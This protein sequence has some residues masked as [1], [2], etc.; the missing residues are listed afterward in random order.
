MDDT[1]ISYD[2]IQEVLDGI[3]Q[4]A[5][6]SFADL[7]QGMFHGD[8]EMNLPQLLWNAVIDAAGAVTG[9]NH[10]IFYLLALA[11]VGAVFTNFAQMLQKKQVAQTAFY[12]TYMLFFSALAA[13]Y[14]V[15]IR[16]TADGMEQVVSFMK[17]LVP[18]YFMSL[19]FAADAASSA[20][21]YQLTLI[22]IG[23]VEI[24]LQK[25][26]LPAINIY[27]IIQLVNQIG[28]EPHMTKMAELIE[29]GIH[30]G[31][32]SIFVFIIGLQ[33]IQGLVMPE[34]SAAKKNLLI[35]MGGA[36]PGVGNTFTAAAETIISSASLLK[37]A[38][39]AAGLLGL[40]LVCI[41]PV[42]RLA[43]DALLYH[44]V[45]AL[46]QP[47]ADKRILQSVDGMT[48]AIRLLLHM[49]TISGILFF[50]SIAVVCILSR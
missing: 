7:V 42:A 1:D 12:A 29:K 45:A 22:A 40:T 26:A 19:A 24:F 47:V 9:Q 44:V 5:S 50:I 25:V 33:V 36:V 28:T 27:F 23:L 35:R 3:F 16:E 4:N 21:F 34:I 18:A 6:F 17:A 46:I 48:A 15:I 14:Q 38:I 13:S 41:I 8:S 20:V 39:G 31:L 2:E 10:L 11:L 43:F 32:K 30:W 49:V 37:S